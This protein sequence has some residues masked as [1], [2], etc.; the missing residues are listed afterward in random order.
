MAGGAGLGAEQVTGTW[1]VTNRPGT[2][3]HVS[4]TSPALTL[5]V[6]RA[7]RAAPAVHLAAHTRGSPKNPAPRPFLCA[8]VSAIESPLDFLGGGGAPGHMRG[9]SW[10]V[11]GT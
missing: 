10:G 4:Q 11:T 5:Q 7:H 2:S 1:G 8:S 9:I 6:A 3:P